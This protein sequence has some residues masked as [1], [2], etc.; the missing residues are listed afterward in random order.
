MQKICTIIILSGLLCVGDSIGME[1]DP[2]DST[3]MWDFMI[4]DTRNNAQEFTKENS[5]IV[6]AWIRKSGYSDESYSL[7]HCMIEVDAVSG[8]KALLEAGANKYINM[9][10]AVRKYTPLHVVKSKEMAELLL[11]HGADLEIKDNE[12]ATPLSHI[13]FRRNNSDEYS[14]YFPGN[15]GDHDKF[16]ELRKYLLEQ[17]ANPNAVD[18][19]GYGLL[20]R[21]VGGYSHSCC[22]PQYIRLLMQF[23]ANIEIKDSYGKTAYDCAIDR[24]SHTE[25]IL[26]ALREFNIFF[27]RDAWVKQISWK[28]KNGEWQTCNARNF[29]EFL[30]N[31]ASE[32]KEY[33][34][35]NPQSYK[36]S[37]IKKIL[38]DLLEM[39]QKNQDS[40]KITYYE[41]KGYLFNKVN[42]TDLEKWCGKDSI[43]YLC[44]YFKI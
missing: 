4:A 34:L 33:M 18:K 7:L 20:H 16:N 31:G 3:I 28:N 29:L 43:D 6:D 40:G 10:T 32:W 15:K 9:A 22:Y 17:G 19:N 23:G 11:H 42:I 39:A 37:G 2:I 1:L 41:G 38:A 5:H 8:V 30:Q 24:I 44:D 35:D 26:E 27:V 13:L 21:S 36:L 14:G 25:P 12:E